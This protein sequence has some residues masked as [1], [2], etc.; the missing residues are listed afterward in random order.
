MWK[1]GGNG[2]PFP[3]ETNA[4][5]AEARLIR[6]MDPK[7]GSRGERV[8]HES[9]TAGF[10]DRG[11]AAVGEDNA[12]S[13]ISRGDGGRDSCRPASDYEYVGIEHDLRSVSPAEGHPT[14]ARPVRSRNRGRQRPG[15]YGTRG[16]DAVV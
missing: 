15:R 7:T 2:V 10:V 11:A 14:S 4:P 13:P 1:V 6:E 12:M 8:G 9:F 16:A 3:K 5:K